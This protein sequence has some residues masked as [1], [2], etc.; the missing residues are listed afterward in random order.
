MTHYLFLLH[1]TNEYYCDCHQF[2]ERFFKF[3]MSVWFELFPNPNRDTNNSHCSC[4]P[5]I[6]TILCIYTS[7]L[8]GSILLHFYLSDSTFI[9]YNLVYYFMLLINWFVCLRYFHVPHYYGN[10]RKIMLVDIQF[11]HSN[12]YQI[13]YF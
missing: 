8:I 9:R 10:K 2:K 11:D 7:Y 3:G 1:K 12:T 6:Y 4:L 13:Y 5:S